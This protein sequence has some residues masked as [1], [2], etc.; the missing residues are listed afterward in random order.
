MVLRG[1]LPAP[2]AAGA[3]SGCVTVQ[4][5]VTF[6]RQCGLIGRQIHGGSLSEAPRT[7]QASALRPPRL[8]DD[9]T[10]PTLAEQAPVLVVL[11]AAVGQ[12]HVRAQP[13]SSD[14]ARDG[15]DLVERRQELGAR[16]ESR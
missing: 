8:R 16:G 2:G 5:V 11:V 15:A 3:A 9:G 14:P 6:Y 13:R 1:G 4:A 7:T 12:Q 10:D